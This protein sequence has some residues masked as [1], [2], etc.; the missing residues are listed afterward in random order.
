MKTKL[1]ILVLI[2]IIA[3]S[4][5]GAYVLTLENTDSAKINNTTN[6][7]NITTGNKNTSNATTDNNSTNEKTEDLS[8]TIKIK[9]DPNFPTTKKIGKGDEIYV[10]YNSGY[11]GQE[12]ISRGLLIY[13]MNSTDV[14]EG[15]TH[16]KISQA[17]V[18]F[19]DNNNETVYKTYTPNNGDSIRIEVPKDL[20]PISATVHYK[21]R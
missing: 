7:N 3:I 6:T 15:K 19:I 12:D 10:F 13:I 20:T 11:N 8:E 21:A 2:L 5:I 1:I 16:F 4:G 9:D 17:I 14:L 18:K